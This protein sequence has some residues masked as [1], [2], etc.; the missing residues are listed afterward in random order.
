M[1]DIGPPDRT[2][3]HDYLI[4]PLASLEEELPVE[5]PALAADRDFVALVRSFDGSS[6]S[7]QLRRL[8]G[9][10]LTPRLDASYDGMLAPKA[11]PVNG[12]RI[13]WIDDQHETH[14]TVKDHLRRRARTLYSPLAGL[15]RWR[16]SFMRSRPLYCPT[17]PATAT[18]MPAW[19]TWRISE[20]SICTPGR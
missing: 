11:D 13:L 12:M 18:S 16:R 15:R 2:S 1:M 14:R 10:P 4:S 19:R 9:K 20:S 7:D 3:S 5:F 8:P 17:S 6:N